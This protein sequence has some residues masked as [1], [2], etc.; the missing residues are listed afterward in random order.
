MTGAGTGHGTGLPG[1]ACGRRS[2]LR[3]LAERAE[4]PGGGLDVTGSSGRG[5]TLVWHVPVGER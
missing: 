2:G 3:N 5:T 4:Q 1:P